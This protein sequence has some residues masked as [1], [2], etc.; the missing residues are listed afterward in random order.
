[1]TYN[2][3]HCS[4]TFATPYALKRHISAKH[5]YTIEEE[6]GGTSQSQ[7]NLPYEE[8]GLWD[9]DVIM[10]EPMAVESTIEPTVESHKDSQF[11]EMMV[12]EESNVDDESD[13]NE[14]DEEI[15][16]NLTY[17][18]SI[19]PEDYCGTT[20][21]NAIDDKT[22]PPNT[23]WPNDIYREF[24]EIVM[25]YQLS[26]SCGDRIIKLINKSKRTDV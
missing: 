16:D 10:E 17:P 3:S 12:S 13:S 1:M 2:C 18:L 5:Q 21:D 25:E 7:L 22:H 20:L 8:P 19:D 15:D 26:N 23:E 14:I 4:R 11:P 9:D 6:E 24:M